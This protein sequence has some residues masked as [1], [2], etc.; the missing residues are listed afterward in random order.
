MVTFPVH[1]QDQ[2]SCLI[3]L[4]KVINDGFCCGS[5]GSG[6]LGKNIFIMHWKILEY[7][8]LFKRLCYKCLYISYFIID[9]VMWLNWFHI[10]SIAILINYSKEFVK[11]SPKQLIQ[12]QAFSIRLHKHYHM[13][14]FMSVD[15]L[16]M[17]IQTY[18]NSTTKPPF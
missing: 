5:I 16:Y 12:S 6:G 18:S 2:L 13:Q 8:N 7:D 14:V 9:E 1:E 3:I 15:K 10:N 17:S 4:S 11:I